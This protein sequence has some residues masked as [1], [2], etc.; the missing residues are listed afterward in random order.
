MTDLKTAGAEL[1]QSYNRLQAWLGGKNRI[2][3][4]T[5]KSYV[6]DTEQ[7]WE[8]FA[9]VNEGNYADFTTKEALQNSQMGSAIL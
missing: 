9:L 4:V 6:A 7:A 5:F 2:D 3:T 1:A 8:E